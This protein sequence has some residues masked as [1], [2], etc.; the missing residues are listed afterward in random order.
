MLAIKKAARDTRNGHYQSTVLNY[1]LTCGPAQADDVIIIVIQ[2]TA[3]RVADNVFKHPVKIGYTL[4]TAFIG[5]SVYAL[6]LMGDEFFAGFVY[7][8]LV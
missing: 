7:P 1:G 2:V 6:K 5:H 4:E 8:H 3:G